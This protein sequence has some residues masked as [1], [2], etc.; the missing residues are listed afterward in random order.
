MKKYYCRV[1]KISVEIDETEKLKF[2]PL[3]NSKLSKNNKNRRLK[4]K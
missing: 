4:T 1:C 3:C 2:C